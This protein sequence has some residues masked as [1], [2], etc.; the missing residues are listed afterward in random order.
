MAPG[1]R[2]RIVVDIRAFAPEFRRPVLFSVVDKLIELGCQDEIVIV[3]DHDPSGLG[4]QID[5]RR[6]S[7]GVFEYTSSIRS[8]GAW[9]ALLQRK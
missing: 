8:D 2:G 4:Y 3:S 9:V 6:E 1:S 7:R 5:L